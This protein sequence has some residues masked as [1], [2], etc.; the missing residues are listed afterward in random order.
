MSN[1]KCLIFVLLSKETNSISYIMSSNIGTDEE[2]PV[3]DN[4]R[5][6]QINTSA[7]SRKLSYKESDWNLPTSESRT[8]TRHGGQGRPNLSRKEEISESS[9]SEDDLYEP[10]SSGSELDDLSEEE[11]D[12]QAP[13]NKKPPATRVMLEV[14]SL[15]NIMN[16]LCQCQDCGGQLDVEIKTTCIASH[17][18]ASCKDPTCGH[19]LHSDPPAPTT[20]HENNNDNYNQNADYAI[21]V[22]HV[23]GMIRNGDGCTEAVR[24]LGLMGSPNDT[25]MD[26]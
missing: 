20:I 3:S 26:G 1:A 7:E 14:A 4:T 6:R 8:R 16:E 18:K 2:T 17:V 21:N 12:K 25:T 15:T 13:N 24:M 5:V 19:I 23:L 9:G 10:G 11:A 22:L